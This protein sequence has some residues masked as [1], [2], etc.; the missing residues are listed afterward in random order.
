MEQYIALALS[1]AEGYYFQG[2]K[3][4]EMIFSGHLN[5]TLNYTFPLVPYRTIA[6]HFLFSS[7]KNN[8]ISFF[9]A[10]ACPK[11]NAYKPVLNF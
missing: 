8:P 11:K 2:R 7:F 1:Y 5:K 9:V 10:L 4:M 6:Y 3:Q